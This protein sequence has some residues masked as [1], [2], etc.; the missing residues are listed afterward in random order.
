MLA[1]M[2][3]LDIRPLRTDDSGTA[4]VDAVTALARAEGWPTFA[5][6]EQLRRVADAPG[7]LTLV[8]I[9]PTAPDPGIVGFAHA[10]TNG[11]HGYLSVIAVDASWRGRGVGR[12]LIAVL[13][14]TSGI[15]RLDLLS[16]PESDAF[17]TRLP[18]HQL[19]GFRLYPPS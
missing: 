14:Q 17:Y 10:L 6:P 3:A 7:T 15:E 13:F 9:E 16:G 12:Q 1:R 8:A 18:N 19:T 11:H 4:A 5:D 2:V